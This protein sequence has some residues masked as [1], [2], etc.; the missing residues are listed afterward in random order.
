M[1]GEVP[2]GIT[3]ILKSH[4]SPIGYYSRLRTN[5]VRRRCAN[6]G[7]RRANFGEM[8]EREASWSAARVRPVAA[9]S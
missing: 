4:R 6:R 2:A 1:P 9:L 3:A 7:R 8:T 5:R